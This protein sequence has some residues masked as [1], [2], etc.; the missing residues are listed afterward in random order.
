MPHTPTDPAAVLRAAAKRA[1]QIGDPLH[2]A[3]AQLLDGVM[4]SSR[5]ADHEE[6]QRWC[7]PDTCDLSAAL[8]VARVVLGTTT[9]AAETTTVVPADLVA[10]LLAAAD[11]IAGIDFHPNARARSLD[12]ATG[13]V[14]RLRRLAA[15]AQQ[16]APAE[17]EEPTP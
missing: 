12:I 13:L 10:G 16:P 5:E 11:E 1:R 4:S 2:T 3:V 7:S 9:P 17:T 8:A 15:E 14:R 6:C